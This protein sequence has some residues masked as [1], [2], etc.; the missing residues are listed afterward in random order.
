MSQKRADEYEIVRLREAE[1]SGVAIAAQ[2]LDPEFGSAKAY[3]LGIGVRRGDHIGDHL[4]HQ[5]T[6]DASVAA[7]QIETAL[8]VAERAAGC[9]ER[10]PDVVKRATATVDVPLRVL[11]ATEHEVVDMNSSRDARVAKR[12]QPCREDRAGRSVE[13][14]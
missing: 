3:R 6:S 5:V 14:L 12:K 10:L 4:S 13:Q 2:W 7:G 11:L 1:T 9:C 8:D